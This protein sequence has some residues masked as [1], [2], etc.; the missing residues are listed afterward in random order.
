MLQLC[1]NQ[2]TGSIPTKLSS[3]KKL[4]VVALQSNHLTGAI[5]ASLGDL[6]MLRRLD[7]SFNRLF[8]SIPQKLADAPLLEVLDIRNNTLS[9]NVPPALKRLNEGFL[10]ENN[11]ELCAAG[12]YLKACSA[13]SRI[14]PNRPEPFGTS[15]T[16]NMPETADLQP[17]CNQTFC[18]NSSKSHQAS[19]V[20][21]AIVVT[22]ALLAF[23]DNKHRC[24]DRLELV[25]DLVLTWHSI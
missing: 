9:G 3:L 5:P 20:V 23:Q 11:L 1:Y 12:F 15:T 2:L 16:R 6:S 14:N 21:R 19:V 8:G 7:L 17:P 18:S 24:Y 22:N 10:Y 25:L 4:S 13:S